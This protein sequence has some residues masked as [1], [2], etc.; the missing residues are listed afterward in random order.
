MN[1]IGILAVGSFFLSVKLPETESMTSYTK[2]NWNLYIAHSHQ[3]LNMPI[4]VLIFIKLLVAIGDFPLGYSLLKVRIHLLEN[5]NSV[6][7]NHDPKDIKLHL[8]KI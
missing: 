1:L 3:C 8:F 4:E 5:R 6:K 7:D 2:R